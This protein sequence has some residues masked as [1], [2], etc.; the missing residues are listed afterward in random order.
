VCKLVNTLATIL[1]VAG[2]ANAVTT[3]SIESREPVR[4]GP[5]NY[6]YTFSMTLENSDLRSGDFFVL[7]DFYGYRPGSM[8]SSDLVNWSMDNNATTGPYPSS[9]PPGLSPIS[10]RWIYQADVMTS[11]SAPI[12][13]RTFSASSSS[14]SAL[15]FSG[16][17]DA[18][19]SD[20]IGDAPEPSSFF[21]VA[22][23]AAAV[24]WLR[25]RRSGAPRT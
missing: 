17:Q 11:A 21:M 2:V 4:L 14:I 18:P 24:I 5:D 1:L 22:A 23:G 8:R 12:V 20:F 3:S 9:E 25:A 16:M 19:F 10:L 6:Q 13:L 15:W 7:Y